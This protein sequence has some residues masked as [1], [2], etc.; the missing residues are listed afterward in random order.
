MIDSFLNKEKAIRHN[1]GKLQWGLVDFESLT[2][3]VRVLEFGAKKYEPNNWKK[4]LNTVELTECLLR[5]TFAYLN[6]E[7]NDPES[8]QSHIGHIMCNAMF[9]MYMH[10]N[11]PEFDNRS[12]KQ[13]NIDSN[14]VDAV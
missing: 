3:M 10:A 1:K 6:G 14:N 11:K 4:G 12:K 2:P 9:I 7:D 5:H 8:G 13:E